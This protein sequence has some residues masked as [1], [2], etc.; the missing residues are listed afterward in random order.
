MW[1]MCLPK[2]T[3]WVTR[4]AAIA[5]WNKRKEPAKIEYAFFENTNANEFFEYYAKKYHYPPYDM[6]NEIDK[7]DNMTDDEVI[8]EFEQAREDSKDEELWEED[9]FGLR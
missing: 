7:I 4:E 5:A 3:I 2:D 8:K 1:Q 9:D 6:S